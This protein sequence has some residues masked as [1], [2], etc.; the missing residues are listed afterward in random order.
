MGELDIR[1]PMSARAGA[2]WNF[3]NLCTRSMPAKRPARNVTIKDIAD[4]LGLTHA[5]V[6]RA[7]NDHAQ[8]NWKTKE[9][10]HAAAKAL[11]YIPNTAART[12]RQQASRVIGLVVP[13]IANPFYGMAARSFA[14]TLAANDLQ[15]ILAVTD[16]DPATE[17]RQVLA[18]RSARV[19]GIAITLTAQPLPAT[20]ALLEG[21]PAVQLLRHLRAGPAAHVVMNDRAGVREATQHVLALGHRRVGYVGTPREL[22]TG[23]ARLRGFSDAMK[24]HG[25]PVDEALLRFGPPRPDFGRTAVT[26][27]WRGAPAPPTALIVASPQLTLGVVEALH[28]LGTA[29]PDDVSLVSYGDADWFVACE[30]AITAVHLPIDEAASRAT[31]VLLAGLDAR[32][33]TGTTTTSLQP[34]LIVRATTG[35]PR[36][37]R[38]TSAPAL[39]ARYKRT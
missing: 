24:A 5:T 9:R 32:S 4:R 10:V 37:R 31:R 12:M 27:L 36:K 15:L 7:L 19:A 16:D 29:I 38:V 1:A 3:A 22:S 34:A 26:E 25:V 28:H 18:L 6:S 39:P 14:E 20:L 2:A 23:L 11:G 33:A 21:I 17:H 35:P 8:T 30:P 13:D